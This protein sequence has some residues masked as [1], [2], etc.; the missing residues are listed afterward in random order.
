MS[1]IKAGDLVVVMRSCCQATAI[2]V[3]RLFRVR[4]IRDCRP[5]GIRCEHCGETWRSQMAEAEK[6]TEVLD[7]APIPWLKRIPPLE[8]LERDKLTE[9]LKE[10]V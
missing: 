4:L 3:G 6:S 2:A 7:H 8:E 5:L 10:I 9:K 1:Q